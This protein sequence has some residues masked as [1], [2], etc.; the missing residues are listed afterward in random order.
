MRLWE[1]TRL[2]VTQLMLESLVWMLE[3]LGLCWRGKTC[4]DPTLGC[5]QVMREF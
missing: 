3:A 5:K 4:R 2:K 1:V